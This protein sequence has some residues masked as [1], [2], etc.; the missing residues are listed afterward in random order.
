[1]TLFELNGHFRVLNG[2]KRNIKMPSNIA[3]SALNPV[4][5]LLIRKIRLGMYNLICIIKQLIGR[6]AVQKKRHCL[7][8][9]RITNSIEFCILVYTM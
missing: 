3:F 5:K 9:R 4:D 1:M 6:I 2:M 8:Q 7:V